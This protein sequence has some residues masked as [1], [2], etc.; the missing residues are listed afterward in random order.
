MKRLGILK[1]QLISCTIDLIRKRKG[2]EGIT[3]REIALNVG[4]SAAN[5]YNH[6]EKLEDLITDVRLQVFKDYFVFF[7]TSKKF[8]SIS[9]LVRDVSS[10]MIEYALDNPGLYTLIYIEPMR[11]FSPEEEVIVDNLRKRSTESFLQ[12]IGSGYPH[13]D[14]YKITKILHGY[15]HGEICRMISGRMV[16]RTLEQYKENTVLNAIHLTELM[17]TNVIATKYNDR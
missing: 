12:I 1:E 8:D 7:E 3:V 16:S 11:A 15:L 6:Y 9:Q 17:V 2:S 14:I 4:C 10:E 5:I 13:D